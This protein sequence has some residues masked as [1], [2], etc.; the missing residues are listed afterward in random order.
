MIPK[1]IEMLEFKVRVLE[2]ESFVFAGN[3]AEQAVEIEGWIDTLN[4]A[5]AE[6]HRF[7]M[8]SKGRYADG[9]IIPPKPFSLNAK[10]KAFLSK[11]IEP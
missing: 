4:K 6:I 3:Y 10:Y 7:E 8:L 5:E 1:L 11:R 9:S 2:A